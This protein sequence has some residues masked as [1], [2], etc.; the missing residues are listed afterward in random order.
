MKAG[1]L[2]KDHL[3]SSKPGQLIARHSTS[4]LCSRSQARGR[5]RAD[6]STYVLVTS[7]GS[8]VTEREIVN[9]FRE[10]MMYKAINRVQNMKPEEYAHKVLFL[11][12]T[13]FS[14]CLKMATFD[15]H[16][17]PFPHLSSQPV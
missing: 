7:S 10:K 9:D 12:T 1:I 17:G 6:E 8:G 16:R 3:L 14:F 13:E 15:G 2:N 5:A 4:F 11:A